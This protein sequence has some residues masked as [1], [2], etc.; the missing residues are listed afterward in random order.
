[1]LRGKFIAIQS[2]LKKQKKISN[3][4]SNLTPKGTRERRINKTHSRRKE[5]I[6]I[7]AE[8]NETE[9]K[10]TIAKSNKTKIR[11]EKGEVTMDTTEIQSIIRDYYKQL[12]AQK[13]DNLEEMDEF[14]ERYKKV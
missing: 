11:N 4:Q 10:K 6:K 9:T 1:M 12:Y 5:I 13:M 14:L 3:K 8:I 7:R 2:S